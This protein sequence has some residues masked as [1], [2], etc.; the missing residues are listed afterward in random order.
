MRAVNTDAKSHL[1]KPPEKCLQEAERAKKQMH[2]EACLQQHRH[3]S[4]FVA[5]ADG[6][7]GVEVTATLKRIASCLATKWW[8]PYSWMCGYA[9][10]RISTTLVRATH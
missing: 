4:P 8:Q 6:F 1:A 9:R 10:S 2:L 7:M 5:S 3:L